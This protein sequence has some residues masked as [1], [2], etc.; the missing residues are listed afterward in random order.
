M[1]RFFAA[2]VWLLVFGEPALA[3]GYDDFNLG[4]AAANRDEPDDAIK[5]LTQALS[6]PDLPQHLHA[7]A[8]YAR[9][10]Q[11]LIKENEALG[12][13]DLSSAIALKPDYTDALQARSEIYRQE[14]KPEAAIADFARV[15]AVVPDSWTVRSEHARF[16]ASLHHYDEAVADFS[17]F[18]SKHP[19]DLYLYFGRADIYRQAGKYDSAIT[20]AQYAHDL[21]AKSAYPYFELA[22]IYL[23]KNDL[24]KA[25]ESA[26]AAVSASDEDADGYLLRGQVQWAMGHYDEAVRSF[27]RS[28]RY[29]K[30]EP[31]AFMWLNMAMS[32][33]S[34][35]PSAG[36]VAD[37]SAG[38]LTEWPG[39]L[40]ALFL[41]KATAEDI[42]AIKL[43]K[44]DI[45]IACRR[46]FYVGEW[47]AG[48]GDNAHARTLLQ[49]VVSSCPDDSYFKA[50]AT[51]DLGRLP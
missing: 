35:K 43:A 20:D 19:H 6:E 30:G 4:V 50:L 46:D 23:E 2:V 44:G 16:L 49:G 28:L 25:L 11:Y 1:R 51:I 18:I 31:T 48:R 3:D 36:T 26:E 22:S 32:R 14:N 47:Y 38:D 41:G 45:Q 27:S 33:V 37:A 39:H 40:V 34:A 21:D 12:L 42:L 13:A 5:Y 29:E 17:T 9:A 24:A 10:L 15:V 8:Y 7:V